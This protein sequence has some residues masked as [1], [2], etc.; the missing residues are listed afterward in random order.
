[1]KGSAPGESSLQQQADPI[2]DCDTEG[3]K[4][5]KKLN[6]GDGYVSGDDRDWCKKLTHS[7]GRVWTKNTTLDSSVQALQTPSAGQV[8]NR[9]SVL[10]V[11]LPTFRRS[12]GYS[13][14]STPVVSQHVTHAR[15]CNDPLCIDVPPINLSDTGT[16]CFEV[17]D[18]LDMWVEQQFKVLLLHL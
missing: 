4:P 16:L 1:M 7:V 11:G 2:S 10:A 14:V 8:G 15:K 5:W 17:S 18:V 3:K 12:V 9:Y 6:G 13:Q